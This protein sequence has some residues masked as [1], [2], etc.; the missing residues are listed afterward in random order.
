ML[1]K[2]TTTTSA[3]SF[4]SPPG[5]KIFK[6]ES[7]EYANRMIVILKTSNSEIKFATA[8]KPYTAWS[9]MTTIVN[10]AE[11]A[12]FDAVID[13]AGNVHLVYIEQTTKYLV[14]VKLTYA[15]GTWTVGSKVYIYNGA[16]T[17]YP[18][19]AIDSSGEL[20]VAYI[21]IVTGNFD[22]YIKNSSDSGATWT[23]GATSDGTLLKAAASNV[24]PKVLPSADYLYVVYSL[25]WSDIK[26]RAKPSGGSTWGSEFTVASGASL[27]EHFDAA[28]TPEG[29]L[30]IVFDDNAIKYREYDG[31]N[32]GSVIVIDASGGEFPQLVF[33]NNIPIIY[34][35][36]AYNSDQ[37]D[38]KYS[39]RATGTFSAPQTLSSNRTLFEKLLLYN[40]S[41]ASYE[42]LTS[43]AGNAT[44][45]DIVH[46]QNGKFLS[47][48]GDVAYLGLASKFRFIKFLLSTAGAGGVVTYNYWDGSNWV[49]FTPDNGAFNLDFADYDLLL[50]DD[51]NSIPLD[52]QKS[53]INGNNLFWIKVETTADFSTA[54]IGS[55]ITAISDIEAVNIRR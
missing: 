34:Y 2:I 46:S 6:I 55:Q 23:A 35:L 47:Q 44:P 40:Y 3:G 7:G 13:S 30:G 45:A 1:K 17:N 8:D 26:L 11:I 18:S 25:D 39:H 38:I 32:W 31:S 54:P 49:A 50:W 52:W 37:I 48:A 24:A 21:K 12:P 43:A 29:L 16:Q 33:Q 20:W 51:L 36:S 14:T 22:L 27:D 9:A 15:N 5:K 53:I 42:D 19:V 28:I 4:G 41:A 10:D